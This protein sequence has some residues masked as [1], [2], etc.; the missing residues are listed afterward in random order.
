LVG[1]GREA[2]EFELVSLSGE[3]IRLSQFRG[4]PTVISFG[5]TW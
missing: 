4:R 1:V 5:T 3:Q 2:P